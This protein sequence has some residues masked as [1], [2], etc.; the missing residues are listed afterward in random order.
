[1]YEYLSSNHQINCSSVNSREWLNPN[2][3]EITIA[4]VTDVSFLPPK[5]IFLN[6]LWLT[7]KPLFLVHHYVREILGYLYRWGKQFL[8]MCLA[9]IIFLPSISLSATFQPLLGI[10]LQVLT[11]AQITYHFKVTYPCFIKCFRHQI[12]P[13]HLSGSLYLFHGILFFC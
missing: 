3:L 13:I 2:D 5:V 11:S 1:M 8:N 9:L 6:F 4:A 10:S 7:G 12:N